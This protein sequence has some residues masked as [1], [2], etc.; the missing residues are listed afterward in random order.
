[1]LY[2]GVY[3]QNAFLLW[4]GVWVW[5][6]GYLTDSANHRLLFFLGLYVGTMPL[7]YAGVGCVLGRVCIMLRLY[8]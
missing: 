3:A 6:V 2:V 1:M 8:P 4:W 5:D 7:G